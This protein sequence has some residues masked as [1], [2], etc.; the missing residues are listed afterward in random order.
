MASDVRTIQVLSGSEIDRLLEELN[1]S[2]MPVELEKNGVRYRL[3]RVHASGRPRSDVWA[4]YDPDRALEGLRRVA[5]TWVG[6]GN[7]EEL[8]KYLR[9]RRR[10]ANRPS[11]EL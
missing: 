8:K 6:L 10:T 11:V 7:P 4:G 2:A 1:V 9:G 3:D 5:G